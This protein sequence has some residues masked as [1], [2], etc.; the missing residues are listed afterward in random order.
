MAMV[1]FDYII[2]DTAAEARDTNPM[3]LGI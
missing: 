3:L 1:T 2:T